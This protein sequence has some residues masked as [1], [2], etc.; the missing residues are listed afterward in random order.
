MIR[1]NAAISGSNKEGPLTIGGVGMTPP[2]LAI[3]R[4]ADQMKMKIRIVAFGGTG[5]AMTAAMG[6]Q[7]DAYVGGGGLQYVSAGI[8]KRRKE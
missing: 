1:E 4:F 7:V 3:Q 6:G 5:V 8:A 2:E